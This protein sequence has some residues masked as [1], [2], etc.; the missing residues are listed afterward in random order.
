MVVRRGISLCILPPSLSL[1][2]FQAQSCA[3]CWGPVAGLQRHIN[4]LGIG[5][6]LSLLCLLGDRWHVRRNVCEFTIVSE[7]SHSLGL[8]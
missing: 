6:F 1:A 7:Q 8:F 3:P 5:P 4:I 2:D